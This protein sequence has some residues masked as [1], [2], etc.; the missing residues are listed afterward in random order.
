M[1]GVIRSV[2]AS[3]RV[4]GMYWK[5]AG[6]PVSLT[7]TLA[8]L[9]KGQVYYGEKVKHHS[10]IRDTPLVIPACRFKRNGVSL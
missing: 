6:Q 2:Y 5:L 8:L 9:V 3:M 10:S 7:M 4:T 1:Q